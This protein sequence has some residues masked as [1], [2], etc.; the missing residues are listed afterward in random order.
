MINIHD[1]KIAL[2]GEFSIETVSGLYE[3]YPDFKYPVRC[4]DLGEIE[5]A[6]SSGLALL[7]YWHAKLV[8]NPEFTGFRNC[9]EKLLNIAKLAGLEKIFDA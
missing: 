2:A 9:P 7:I 8:D 4:I 3:R 5:H 1:G 6:D